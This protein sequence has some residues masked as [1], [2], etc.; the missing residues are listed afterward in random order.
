M[1]KIK[2]N[3]WL[4]GDNIDT[5]IIIPS[6]YCILE[7]IK[8]AASHAMEPLFP[9]FAKEVKS[10][11]IMVTGNNF[12]CG[13]SRE[14]APRVLKELGVGAII[15]KTF[16]RIFLRNAINIGL[17]VFE[18]HNLYEKAHQGD[19]IEI[20]FRKGEILNLRDNKIYNIT[21]LPPFMLKILE[22]GGLANFIKLEKGI[23]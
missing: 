17:P 22:V 18:H 21:P 9:N 6:Q 20:D 13:S 15:A 16:A 1:N 8:D 3:V 19:S 10:G 2:G 7:S 14:Q 5:D 12:G 23:I 4:F 11:D